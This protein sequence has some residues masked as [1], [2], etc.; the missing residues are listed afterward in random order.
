MNR[1]EQDLFTAIQN[2]NLAGVKRALRDGA[3]SVAKDEQGN[4]AFRK[5]A[6]LHN[7]QICDLLINMGV[8][9]D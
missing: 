6:K 9:V 4:T 3:S 8:A 5:A 7:K 2:G 1:L